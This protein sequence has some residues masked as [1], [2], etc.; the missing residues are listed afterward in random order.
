MGI[1]LSQGLGIPSSSRGEFELN[2]GDPV[3]VSESALF[4]TGCRPTARRAVSVADPG[5]GGPAKGLGSK[6][7]CGP[8]WGIV[9]AATAIGGPGGGGAGP[10]VKFASVKILFNFGYVP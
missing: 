3:P 9:L 5:A 2:L 8:D 1:R 6:S 7:C 10:R 4:G